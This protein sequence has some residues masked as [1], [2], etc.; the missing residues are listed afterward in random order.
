[1]PEKGGVKPVFEG[2]EHKKA[3]AGE[4]AQK[5]KENITQYYRDNSPFQGIILENS[6]RAGEEKGKKSLDQVTDMIL[7]FG[8]GIGLPGGRSLVLLPASLDRELIAHRISHSLD[9]PSL[10][11]FWADNPEG[12]MKELVSFL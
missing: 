10:S 2:A 5:I 9:I 6:G 7:C 1:M 3:S 4:A 11:T 12:A 8:I